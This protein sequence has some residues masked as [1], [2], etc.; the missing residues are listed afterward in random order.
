MEWSTCFFFTQN[1]DKWNEIPALWKLGTAKPIHCGRQNNTYIRE[2]FNFKNNSGGI[3]MRRSAAALCA[4]GLGVNTE[5][6]AT[7]D[8]KIYRV[9]LCIIMQFFIYLFLNI[10]IISYFSIISPLHCKGL[11]CHLSLIAI[12]SFYLFMLHCTDMYTAMVAQRKCSCW[13][14]KLEDF[15]PFL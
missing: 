10:N 7:E 6:D 15:V 3:C 12:S 11:A 8:I 4:H 5:R 9:E 13:K 2:K 14:L 1:N